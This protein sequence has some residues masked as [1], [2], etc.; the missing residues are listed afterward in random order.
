MALRLAR[1]QSGRSGEDIAIAYLERQGYR[2]VA[3]NWRPAKAG[4]R[5][6]VDV[7][8]WHSSSVGPVLC[9][10]EV[11]TRTSPEGG[12]PQEA[13]TPAKQRQLCKLANAYVSHARPGEVLCRFDVVEV[14]L[15]DG[16]PLPR[17]ALHQNAFEY[18]E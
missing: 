3:R 7:I 9:F 2:V 16:E 8:A 11:K 15:L 13:V 12:S 14:W 4:L 17:V 10:V 18:E 1:Q 5:G 6:E